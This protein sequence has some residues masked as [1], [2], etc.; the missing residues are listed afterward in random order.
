VSFNILL[1]E[2]ADR[3]RIADL[4]AEADRFRRARRAGGIRRWAARTLRRLADWLE[5][6]LP[7][8]AGVRIPE[9]RHPS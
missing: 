8:G 5:P 6:A 1:M 2:Q 9:P 3:D 4:H 7:G